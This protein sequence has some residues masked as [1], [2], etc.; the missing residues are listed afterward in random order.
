MAARTAA[1]SELPEHALRKL[2]AAAGEACYGKYRVVRELGRGGMGVV[3][4]A[5]DEELA[6]AVA[7]KVLALPP[8][9]DP[10]L[11]ERFQRE[12][13]AVAS[14]SHPNIAAIYEATGDWI[15]MQLV[16]GL[17]MSA[18]PRDD[19]ARLVRLVRDAAR[20]VHYAHQRGVVHRDLKP[21]NLLVE[22]E[23]VVV[24]DFGLAKQSAGD[25]SLSVSGHV[26]GTPAYMAPEQA[27]GRVRDVDARTDV[28][29]LGA[30]LYDLL[31]G[32]PPFVER[33]VVRLLR[34]IVDD[35]A[36]RLRALVRDVPADLETIVRKC[37]SKEPQRR[38][39]SAAALADDLTRWLE[40]RPVLAQPPSLRYRLGKFVRR[41]RAA[42][43]IGGVAS[44]VVLGALALSVHERGRR[45]A[46]KQAI[47]LA[48]EVG[49]ILD[50]AKTY[51]RLGQI[52]RAYER[53][54]AGIAACR[55][56]SARHDVAEAWLVLGRLL[57]ARGQAQPAIAALDRAVALDARLSAARVERGLVRVSELTLRLQGVGVHDVAAMD[58]G[59]R[60]ERARALADLDAA[61]AGHQG[62]T[63]AD[64]EHVRAERARLTGELD[65]ARAHF[66]EV[67][68]L[69]PVREEAIAGLSRAALASGDHARA[70]LLAMQALDIPR[71]F[72]AAYAARTETAP[73]AAAPTLRLAGVAGELFDFASDVGNQASAF[74]HRSVVHARAAAA[75][76][77]PRAALTAWQAAIAA[78]GDALRLEPER[79][80]VLANRAV[81]RC[82]AARALAALGRDEDS[83]AER[84]RAFD[85]LTAAASAAPDDA[86]I[87]ANRAALSR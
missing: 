41:R 62:L 67:L 20:A 56:F 26:L 17:P 48:L 50:E 29:G 33:D 9:G 47:G 28:Y 60:A 37:L 70:R 49:A 73:L 76:T 16:D 2:L 84:A 74:A 53:L 35:E 86:V 18:L 75:E 77:D 82:A 11:R 4:E 10:A 59:A 7:L 66:E 81:Y 78:A 3:Y 24:T 30:T 40:G 69:D 23:R 27:Q 8:G 45:A 79:A 12:A 34:C 6:R 87:E 54:D 61:L 46:S 39:P 68:R 58:E 43:A 57:R 65:V 64:V 14:L 15:A 52:E 36:P 25:S 21:H 63:L 32:R 38:Y 31:A 19:R 85:D 83:A 1:M 22:G 13:L 42:V 80:D 5:R 55:A 51:K 44:L 72:G 71:G